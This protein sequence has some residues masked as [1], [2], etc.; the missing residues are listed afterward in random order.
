[1]KTADSAR[2]C[3]R[4]RRTTCIPPE[5]VRPSRTLAKR[6]V[7]RPF[8]AK[9]ATLPYKTRADSHK[10]RA[11]DDK[12]RRSG[13]HVNYW[14]RCLRAAERDPRALLSLLPLEKSTRSEFCPLLPFFSLPPPFFPIFPQGLA[15]STLPDHRLFSLL[16]FF[17]DAGST[18]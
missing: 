4:P 10:S 7:P 8:R 6:N 1:M 17:H 14:I 12:A 13:C 9:G 2:T 15:L 3:P 5:P 18:T 11:R 16:Y